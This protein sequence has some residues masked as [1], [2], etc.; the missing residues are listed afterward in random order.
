M[1]ETERLLHRPFTLLDLD[2]L[3]E[4][5]G[6]AAVS[7]YIGGEEATTKDWIKKRLDHYLQCY[8]ELGFGVQAL[9]WKETGEIIGWSGLQPLPDSNEIQLT[10]GLMEAYWRQ[11]LGY[12]TGMAWLKV[13]FHTLELDRIVA[14]T[15]PQNKGSWKL[16]EKLGMTFE[17]E[18]HGYTII[19]KRYAISNA[20][21]SKRGLSGR[22]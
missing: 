7:K 20:A 9:L 14:L 6:T 12:E 1:L 15:A 22:K 8:Q 2:R 21:F 19:C 13:G 17:G 11:G 16:M 5:R 4:V 3:T 18:Q 10:Y